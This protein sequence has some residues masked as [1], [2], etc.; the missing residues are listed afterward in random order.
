MHIF[1]R[2]KEKKELGQQIQLV[3]TVKIYSD[4]EYSVKTFNEWLPKWKISKK[5]YLNKDIIDA[6]DYYLESALFKINYFYFRYY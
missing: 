6:V 1:E 2:I 3:Q 5:E 4:S